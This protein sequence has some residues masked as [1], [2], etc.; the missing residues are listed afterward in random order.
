M[1]TIQNTTGPSRTEVDDR[2]HLVLSVN[3]QPVALPVG[4][5]REILMAPKAMAVPGAPNW[6]R[7]VI[8]VRGD[9]MPLVDLRSRLGMPTQDE[10]TQALL[11][12]LRD[13]EA[14]HHRWLRELEASVREHRAFT[15]ARDPSKCAFGR[16]YASYRPENL[17]LQFLWN[18][19]DAP[20]R[21]IHAFADVVLQ[22]A[23]RG[24]QELALRQIEEAR[25]GALGRLTTLFAEA[26]EAVSRTRREL[27]VVLSRDG[28]PVALCADAADSVEM[29]TPAE[30]SAE[31]VAWAARG[32]GLVSGLARRT[33]DDGLLLVLDTDALFASSGS[34]VT[35]A[36]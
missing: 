7:G 5:V 24:E 2:L 33:G 9:V 16:W 25:T 3:R 10:D 35:A 4:A 36:A 15:L 32:R 11:Q 29:L 17:A 18:G 34:G 1:S 6:V 28:A 14:D 21:E 13:R 23:E 26:A 30:D 22:A 12:L 31:L 20:H 8:D 27:A 19:F